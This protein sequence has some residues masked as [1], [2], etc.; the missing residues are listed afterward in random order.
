MPVRADAH[1]V[2]AVDAQRDP[3]ARSQQ[4][5]GGGRLAE[6]LAETDATELRL[7]AQVL[8]PREREQIV[9]ESFQLF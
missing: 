5:D 7:L 4:L 3:L 8:E 9:D 2:A 6:Q 1:R